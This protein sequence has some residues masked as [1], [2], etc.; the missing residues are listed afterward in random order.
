MDREIFQKQIDFKPEVKNRKDFPF[1]NVVV[2]G[3][4]G[5]ALPARA[6]FFLDSIFPIWL[7][8]DYG[9]PQKMEG[10]TLCIA[11]SYSGNTLETLSFAR[12]A[13]EKKLPLAI[14]TSGGVLLEMAQK[15]NLPHIII[16]EGMQPR[17]SVI[18][19]LKSLLVFLGKEELIEQIENVDIAKIA[20][21]AEKLSGELGDNIPIIYSS[22]PNG[23]LGYIWKI[24]LNENAKVPSWNNVFPELTHNEIQGLMSETSGG[25][26]E[27]LKILMLLD[28][29]D[30]KEIQNHMG[31]FL[32]SMGTQVK[33][34]PITLPKG[35]VSKLLATL[36]LARETSRF[37]AKSRGV[38]PEN[39]ELI[40]SFK[41]KLTS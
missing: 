16:P 30:T 35:K 31:A 37:L 8:N 40:E 2:G 19:M 33:I 36:I 6:L 27:K 22:A 14:I 41:K 26:S 38:S 34:I 39:I 9:I 18:Y 10:R 1:D 25:L 11:I 17:D 4:G 21:E 12:E 29:E 32:G 23:T 13:V 5:S 28:D 7:H 24:N 15:E 3:M 20:S